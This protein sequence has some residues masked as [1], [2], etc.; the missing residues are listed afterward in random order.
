MVPFERISERFRAATD[1]P[2]DDPLDGFGPSIQETNQ[3]PD[4]E[5]DHLDA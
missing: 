5:L 2:R 4:F 3:M 1:A